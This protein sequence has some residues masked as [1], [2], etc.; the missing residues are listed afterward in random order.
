MAQDVTSIYNLALSNAGID[1]TV[2]APTERSPEAEKCNL[3]YE[4]VRDYVFGMA[5]WPELKKSQILALSA[6]RDENV[7]WADADP[8][9]GYKYAFSFPSDCVVPRHLSDYSRFITGASD[10]ARLVY[11][12]KSPSILTYTARRTNPALWSNSLYTA[13]HTALAAAIVMQ[14]TGKNNRVKILTERTDSHVMQVRAVSAR[15]QNQVME[16][17]PQ[18]ITARGFGDAQRTRY[19]YPL[20]SLLVN[21]GV[22]VT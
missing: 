16:T 9:P 21:S 10:S 13:V 5:D 17:L 2:S 20:N 4:T 14:M 8:H 15:E 6:T 7:D 3:H 12:N 22:P 1:V 11:C 19:Y 18:W